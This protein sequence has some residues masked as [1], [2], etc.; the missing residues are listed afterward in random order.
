M[1]VQTD[2]HQGEST[3]TDMELRKAI[4]AAA[5]YITTRPWAGNDGPRIYCNDSKG[6]T[7]GYIQGAT[8]HHITG[9]R[10][11]AAVRDIFAAHGIAT[12]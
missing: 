7:C 10:F 2:N 8:Y 5:P 6:R 4:E 3:M 1:T 11:L 9:S 12:A